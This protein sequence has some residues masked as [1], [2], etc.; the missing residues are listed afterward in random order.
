MN[1]RTHLLFLAAICCLVTIVSADVPHYVNFQGTLA[2][3]AG[4]PITGTRNMQFVI[5]DDSL[6]GSSLW[7]ETRPSVV[8]T[9]G[10]FE[11]LLGSVT[12]FPDTLFN[13][14]QRWLQIDVAGQALSPR[15]SLVSVPY[16]MKDDSWT[17]SGN[18]CYFDRSG[19]VGIGVTDPA[20]K[21]HVSGTIRG[22][23]FQD[24]D[25]TSYYVDPSNQNV[26]AVLKGGVGIGGAPYRYGPPFFG[27]PDFHLNKDTS[28]V[29]IW[30]GATRPTGEI[31]EVN[32]MGHADNWFDPVAYA[33]IGGIIISNSMYRQGALLFYTATGNAL[34]APGYKEQMRIAPN[35]NVGIGTSNP[36]YKLHVVGSVYV[37][38]AGNNSGVHVEL[39]NW[40]GLQVT[41]AGM[42]GVCVTDADQDGILVAHA[43]GDGVSVGSAGDC[44]IDAYGTHGNHLRS[45]GGAYYGLYAHSVL[46]QSTSPGLY[47]YGTE[48]VTGQISSTVATGTPPL[49]VSSTTACT[50]LNADMLDGNHGNKY[51][52]DQASTNRG[53]QSGCAQYSNNQYISFSPPFSYYPVVVATPEAT[54]VIANIQG[55]TSSGFTLKL[56]NNDGTAYVGSTYV[57]WIAI[58]A[59]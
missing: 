8:V 10:F 30:I 3:S 15:T 39:T 46:D 26:A 52:Y 33:G 16:A 21:L 54:G 2:D 20:V 29:E 14:Q 38:S 35:G 31:G 42:D 19:N 36:W 34:P 18:N 40:H 5:Y 28:Y 22:Q 47:V 45:D 24:Q 50:N 6:A 53:F 57:H 41:H 51:L 37:D 44:G 7:S 43:D 1:F 27:G 59:R 23:G 32:F 49:N 11:L 56:T 25:N 9:D 48:A 58:G 12:P 17:S 13:G 55:W 4:N